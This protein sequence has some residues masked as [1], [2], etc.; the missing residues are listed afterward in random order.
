[1]AR[2]DKPPRP[3][4]SG[5]LVVDKPPAMSSMAVVADIRRR[6]GGARTGHAGTLDP[7]ATGVLVVA[8]GRA[9]KII[10]RLMTTDK[11]YL[12]RI[13]LSAFTTTD[14]LEGERREIAV[15]R[16]PKIV[17]PAEPT[18]AEQPPRQN[19]FASRTG[20]HVTDADVNAE[21]RS[22]ANVTDSNL[23]TLGPPDSEAA[24]SGGQPLGVSARLLGGL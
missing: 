24:Q 16:P 20:P 22:A 1:M 21:D 7:L 5:V 6:A 11:R 23:T 10:S 15:P 19:P 14:D 2:A 17:E 18:L 4:T 13:D 12:T 3:A 9:T 8:L